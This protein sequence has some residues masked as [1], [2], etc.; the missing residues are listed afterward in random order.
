M[1]VTSEDALRAIIERIYKSVE[2]PDLWP[3]PMQ[4]IGDC[5]GGRRSFGLENQ[6]VRC[7]QVSPGQDAAGSRPTAK[8][9]SFSRA[10][11]CECFSSMSKNSA[12]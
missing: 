4:A 5:V 12:S 2:R 6:T 3:D 1:A 8:A 11:T 9:R 7:P 10:R